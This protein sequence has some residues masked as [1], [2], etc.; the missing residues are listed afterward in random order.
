MCK[1]SRVNKIKCDVQLYICSFPRV[2][3]L[4]CCERLCHVIVVVVAK[5]KMFLN[6]IK[7]I[8]KIYIERENPNTM[9]KCMCAISATIYTWLL[10]K[11]I[12]TYYVDKIEWSILLLFFLV[13]IKQKLLHTMSMLNDWKMWR[14]EKWFFKINLRF[15]ATWIDTLRRC[16]RRFVEK[17]TGISTWDLSLSKIHKKFTRFPSHSLSFVVY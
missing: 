12:S 10:A 14:E 5:I 17:K 4:L 1:I 2:H 11:K 6:L 9:N 7:L 16:I 15:G 3:L 13:E 8:A